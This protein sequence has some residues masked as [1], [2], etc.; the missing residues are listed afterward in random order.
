M[1]YKD[2]FFLSKI[3]ISNL[4]ESDLTSL[5]LQISPVIPGKIASLQPTTLV[6]TTGIPSAAASIK[7]NE[8]FPNRRGGAEQFELL[9]RIPTKNFGE[10]VLLR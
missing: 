8:M 7:A 9:N 5:T 4:S 6:V 1:P 2:L 10:G 3:K